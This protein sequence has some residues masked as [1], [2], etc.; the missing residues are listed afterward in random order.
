[1]SQAITMVEAQALAEW[2]SERFHC[3]IVR[4]ENAVE[5]QMLRRA[6]EMGT[7][8]L[9]DIEDLINNYSFTIGPMVYISDKHAED[10]ETFAYIVVHECEHVIQFYRGKLEFMFLYLTEGEARVK[11]EAQAYSAAMEWKLA[12][13]LPLPSL[14]GLMWPLEGGAYLLKQEHLILGR[15]I[16]EARATSAAGGI[17]A[18][19][20]AHEAIHWAELNAPHLLAT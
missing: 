11:Y 2:M 9:L 13:G 10:P 17:V 6:L 1:M 8:G 20:S 12:R 3:R 5:F 18:S 19:E 15:Q 16:L 14:D 4:R 7:L